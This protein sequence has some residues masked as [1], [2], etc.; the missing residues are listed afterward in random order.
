[1]IRRAQTRGIKVILQNCPDY[2]GRIMMINSVLR[3]VARKNAVFLLIMNRYLKDCS[4]KVSAR[5]I[6]MHSIDRI[7][8]EKVIA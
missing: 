7:A 4:K 6:I 2:S 3:E 1:M 5:M 8:M